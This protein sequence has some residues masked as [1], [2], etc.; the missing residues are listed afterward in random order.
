MVAGIPHPEF[1]NVG[2]KVELDYPLVLLDTRGIKSVEEI[3]GVLELAKKARKQLFIV[4]TSISDSVL[5]TLIYNRRKNIV[6]AYPLILKDY[7]TIAKDYFKQLAL[8]T[9]AI[10]FDQ[11]G[12]C[13]LQDI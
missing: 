7:G 1:K 5:S 10:I 2:D 11:Y 12:P 8:T 6:E 13:P 3:L 9:E 4:S